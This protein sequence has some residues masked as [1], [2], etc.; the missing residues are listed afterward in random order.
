M[1]AFDAQVLL[2]E[3]VDVLFWHPELALVHVDLHGV[4]VV[5][6]PLLSLVVTVVVVFVEVC[7]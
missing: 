4:V 3:V 7:A 6:V 2:H 1:L 5:P